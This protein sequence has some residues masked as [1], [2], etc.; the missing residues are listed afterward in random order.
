MRSTDRVQALERGLAILEYVARSEAGAG[1]REA[2]GALQLKAPTVHNLMRTL[3]A[4]GYLQRGG[5]PVRYS[6]GPSA[7][8]LSGR[9]SALPA[10]VSAEAEL[11]NLHARHPRVVLTLAQASTQSVRVVLRMGPESPGVVQ[12]P[13]AHTLSAYGSSSALLF[14]AFWSEDQRGAFALQHPF[15][16]EASGLWTTPDRLAHFLATVRQ[17][18]VAVT[19]FPGEELVKLAVPW[20]DAAG[21][22]VGALGCAARA[23]ELD[24]A[25]QA[26]LIMEL[27]ST[28]ERLAKHA[29]VKESSK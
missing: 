19:C 8:K 14:Q 7:Q 27:K 13:E 28:A 21:G 3:T 29:Q 25:A 23:T 6:L 15:W 17:A 4:R 18:G 20:F 5:R 16:E 1:V 10:R 11:R 12:R 9:S 2:A 26:A 24:A 22:M